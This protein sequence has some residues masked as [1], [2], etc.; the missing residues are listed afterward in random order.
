LGRLLGR[1]RARDLGGDLVAGWAQSL[2]HFSSILLES[3]G[4]DSSN[5]KNLRKDG[6][7][8][9]IFAEFREVF[10]INGL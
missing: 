3:V 8:R 4:G 9:F 6:I 2:E 1:R 7:K 10:R 5:P